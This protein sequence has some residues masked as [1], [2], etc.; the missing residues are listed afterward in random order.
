MSSTEEN[1]TKKQHYVP[2]MLLRNWSNDGSK[3]NSF[4]VEYD[5]IV[6]GVSIDTQAQKHYYYGEDQKIEKLYGM[7]EGE[8]A[9][10]FKKVIESDHMIETMEDKRTLVHFI[11]TQNTRTPNSLKE[12]N[13]SIS[14]VIKQM[15]KQ[16]GQFNDCLDE[17]EKCEIKLNNLPYMQLRLNLSSF[18]LYSDLNI[19]LLFANSDRHFVIGQDPVIIV[20]PYLIQKKWNGPKRGL[21]L[22]G[23]VVILPISPDICICL[24]DPST[25]NALPEKIYLDNN[26]IDLLNKY[27]FLTTDSCIYFSEEDKNFTNFNNDTKDYRA[28]VSTALQSFDTPS[29]VINYVSQIDYPDFGSLSFFEINE[30]SNTLSLDR[31]NI[32]RTAAKEALVYYK[33][34]P[35]YSKLF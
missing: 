20:N 24:Y 31:T 27:Q 1:K 18:L 19:C 34:N 11:S 22:R 33:S 5:K 16:S 13:D 15:M 9:E 21:A 17:V 30:V 10:L 6:N 4:L 14:Q 23:L 8:T 3:I 28:Q 26:D 2:Q 25:Y 12:V 29:Q 7:I 35:M 32:E